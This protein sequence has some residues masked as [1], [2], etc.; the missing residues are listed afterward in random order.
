VAFSPF[1]IVSKNRKRRQTFSLRG[2]LC[3]GVRV[4]DT[5]GRGLKPGL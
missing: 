4:S 5:L 2:A 3:I 1:F